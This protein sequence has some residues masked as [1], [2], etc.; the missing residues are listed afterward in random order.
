MKKKIKPTE[1][2]LEILQILWSEGPS[3]VRSVHELLSQKKEVF[4]TTTLK[5]MQVMHDKGL[6]KRD[7][8]Q[9]AHI[10]TPSIDRDSIEKTM[11]DKI[12]DTVFKGSTSKMIISAIGN[13]APTKEE[14]REIREM[15][16]QLYKDKSQ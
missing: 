6:L 11:L 10:Y 4:Y 15:I 5:I 16:D 2:E 3:S 1:A 7:T 12:V 13:Q 8:S 14:L 9:R